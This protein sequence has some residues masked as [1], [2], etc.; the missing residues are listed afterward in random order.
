M[1]FIVAAIVAITW[2]IVTLRW[3]VSRRRS[4]WRTRLIIVSVIGIVVASISIGADLRS[5]YLWVA[6]PRSDVEIHIEEI[7]H[8]WQL[9]YQ[10][11]GATFVTANEIHVPAG[12]VVTIDWRSAAL[13]AWSAHDFLPLGARSHFIAEE[14]GADHVLLI[15]LWTPMWR[16]VRVVADPPGAFDRWFANELRSAARIADSE[17]FVSSGCA[18]CHVIRNVAENPS[19]I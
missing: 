19:T 8:W 12:A 6:A 4:P 1:R 14:P 9:A 16:P 7:G 10:R 5:I 18:Y 11:G 3:S 17:L 15:R 2:S 13:G